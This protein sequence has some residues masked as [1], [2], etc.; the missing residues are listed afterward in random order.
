MSYMAKVVRPL[1]LV[2]RALMASQ[3]GARATRD[4]QVY[5]SSSNPEACAALGPVIVRRRSSSR[6]RA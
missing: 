4:V 1:I 3:V 6:P 2:Y 5:V